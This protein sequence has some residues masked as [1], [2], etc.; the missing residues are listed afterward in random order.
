[1]PWQLVPIPLLLPA[2]LLVLFRVA[3][4]AVMA[5]LFS[6]TAI[7][8]RIRIYLA[9]AIALVIFPLVLPSVPARVTFG[10]ALVGVAGEMI[11]GLA[12][13]LCVNLLFVGGQLAGLM[14]G[15][16]A[17]LALARVFNP[18]FQSSSTVLGQ[19][20]FYYTL[21]IFLAV[22]GHRALIRALLD[23]FAT[24]PVLSFSSPGRLTELLAAMAQSGFVLGVKL[25]GPTLIAL[26]LA[27]LC[28][29][30]IN[31]T[32]PQLNILVVGFSIRVAVA[33]VITAATLGAAQQVFIDALWDGL[34][35]IGTTLGL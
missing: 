21:M 11:I 20:Y 33:L 27:T 29:G 8:V 12:M 6:S 1:V 5:P 13:G 7:P 3:G 4:L 9:L 17:G 25:A 15:R 34:D 23:S 2:F 22:G 30:F 26:F 32:V 14:V 24:I 18:L 31:R 19:V 10:E 28:L 16:Q 35:W